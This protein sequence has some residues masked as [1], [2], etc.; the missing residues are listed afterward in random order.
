VSPV[1]SVTARAAS[2]G[3]VGA[4]AMATSF[5]RTAYQNW[6]AGPAR[7]RCPSP[8]LRRRCRGRRIPR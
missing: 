5:M 2:S 6:T 3:R 8:A 1:A 7:V 4:R